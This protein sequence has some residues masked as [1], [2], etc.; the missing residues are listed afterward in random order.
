M[1]WGP[2]NVPEPPTVTVSGRA[3]AARQ[4][5]VEGPVRTLLQDHEGQ[6]RALEERDRHE[7]VGRVARLLPQGLEHDV[8]QVDAGRSRSRRRAHAIS[9]VQPRAPP[10]PTL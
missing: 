8:R 5:V 4:E 3:R 6:G 9:S 10:P 2:V 7:V 1:K